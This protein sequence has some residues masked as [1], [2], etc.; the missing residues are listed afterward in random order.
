[1]KT[2][3][4]PWTKCSGDL[5]HPPL[6][7]WD[8]HSSNWMKAWVSQLFVAGCPGIP[9]MKRFKYVCIYIFFW[10]G[11][12]EASAAAILACLQIRLVPSPG[13]KKG[14]NNRKSLNQRSQ[15]RRH[16]RTRCRPIVERW[17]DVA[18]RPVNQGR[19]GAVQL[20][21]GYPWL[22]KDKD[23]EGTLSNE[24]WPN[25]RKRP[26]QWKCLLALHWW[27]GPDAIHVSSA[28]HS[29]LLRSSV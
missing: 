15:A 29:T 18:G 8:V 26:F 20:P 21:K 6:K 24:Q 11:L 23:Q 10:L 5:G 13:T 7:L 2:A 27:H 16:H 22:K 25:G 3:H 17:S 9:Y 1:M 19:W 28:G 14:W 12:K 4:G